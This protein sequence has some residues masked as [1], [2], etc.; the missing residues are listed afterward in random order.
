VT[1]REIA[2]KQHGIRVGD[3]VQFDMEGRRLT[4]R[5]NRIT[6]RASVLVDDPT[7]PLFSNGG[8][9]M[10]YYVPLAMLSKNTGSG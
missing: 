5:V 8:R 4:G 2:D 6:K 3:M 10:T 7:G 1:S 9:Y